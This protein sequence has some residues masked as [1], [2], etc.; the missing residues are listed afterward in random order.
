MI[1][2]TFATV[3][4]FA[5]KFFGVEVPS[6]SKFIDDAKGMFGLMEDT[7]TL[8]QGVSG[9]GKIIKIEETGVYVNRHPQV[10]LTLEIHADDKRPVY[11][12]STRLVLSITEIPRFQ[13]GARV[14]VKINK[15]DPQRVVAD[16]FR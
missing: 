14:P 6:L 15:N 8:E 16:V 12:A 11:Q 13:P 3:F 10:K 1:V 4:Y 9:T 2:G 7:E 5:P